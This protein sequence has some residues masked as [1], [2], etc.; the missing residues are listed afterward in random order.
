[1]GDLVDAA[2]D[3][4]GFKVQAGVLGSSCVECRVVGAPVDE[5][6]D[7][8]WGDVGQFELACLVGGADQ[9]GAADADFDAGQRFA[10]VVKDL[11]GEAGGA[12]LGGFGLDEEGGVAGEVGGGVDVA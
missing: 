2:L 3:R 7:A 5:Q 6:V 11:A 9:V 8:A 10:L 4:V 12:V 1:M